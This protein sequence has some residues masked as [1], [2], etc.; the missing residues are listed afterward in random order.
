[1]SKIKIF[2]T[3]LRDGE[4][5]PGASLNTAEKIQIALALEKMNVDVIEAGFPIASPDDFKAVNEIAKR[6][7]KSVVCGLARATKED[8]EAAYKAIKPAKKKRI[9]TFLATS[10]VHLK[11]KLKMTREQ[12]LK[13]IQEMVKFARSKVDDVEFSPEDAFRT[14]PE[15]LFQ[16][17]ETA[18][19]AGASTV[20]IPDTV[21][22]ATPLEFGELIADIRCNVPNI[23]EA[24][25]SVHC[26]NDLGLAVANSLAAVKNGAGQIECTV[27]GLGERAGNAALEEVVMALRTRKDYFKTD[28][29]IKVKEISGISKLV[30]NLTGMPVQPNKAIVGDNAFAH[31]AGI[32]QHGVL[33]KRETY[34]IMK[35]EDIGLTSNELVLGKHSGKHGL[36][37]RLK[38]L[39]IALDK[40]QLQEIFTR[41]KE[42]ADKKKKIYDEDLLAL[43]S[44][45]LQTEEQKYSLKL[46]QVICGSRIRPTA[47]VSLKDKEG[48]VHEVSIIADGPIDAVYRAIDSII[49]E[50]NELLEFSIKAIT[51]GKDAQA[52]VFTKIR[53]KGKVYCGYGSSND[54][55][56]ASAKSYL[57]ALNN[58]L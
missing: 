34:E 52:E 54:V 7:K 19:K 48:K 23:K 28:I 41:F 31:E 12:A 58:S 25:I 33:S 26:H 10:D 50:D 38:G 11:Y 42:L 43:V 29:N 56:L 53:K 30:S 37:S 2:D 32:H 24:I 18:I 16:V 15:F 17:V 35:A 20:N 40:K 21:G 8:I 9:H 3:T 13:Q 22:Y 5:S 39:G 45:H 4:Q 27:N 6:V 47:T 57:N 1:M 46:L 14:E 55:I 44:D 49:K 51:S 36:I